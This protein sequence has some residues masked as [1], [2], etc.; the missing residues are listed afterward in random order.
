M[1]SELQTMVT[2]DGPCLQQKEAENL[3]QKM[4]DA[5]TNITTAPSQ[6][7]VAEKNYIT[8]TQGE[9]AYNEFY[10][11]QLNDKADGI[12]NTYQAKF[13]ETTQK[14]QTQIDIYQGIFINFNNVADLY[15]NYKKENS[16]LEKDLR[17]TTNDVL[18]NERKT[19]YQ[20]QPRLVYLIN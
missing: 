14:I 11:E 12:I 18:T 7:Q 10:E 6:F 2:C 1:Y 16:E 4:E 20:D 17:K 15:L 19:F 13:D 9:E 3:K 5:K 8:F